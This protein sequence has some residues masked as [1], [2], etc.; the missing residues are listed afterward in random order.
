MNLN[1]TGLYESA[2]TGKRMKKLDKV[3]GSS[4][5]SGTPGRMDLTHCQ[6]LA[7]VE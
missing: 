3:S 7:F 4:S 6:G 5:E 1:E 2:V